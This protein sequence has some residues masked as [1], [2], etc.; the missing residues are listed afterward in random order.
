MCLEIR[1]AVW[2]VDGSAVLTG[3][4]SSYRN[5]APKRGPAWSRRP[6][7]EAVRSGTRT[8]QIGWAA[9]IFPKKI[10]MFF[11]NQ[12]ALQMPSQYIFQ[13]TPQIISKLTLSPDQMGSGF[14]AKK[15]LSLSKINPRSRD[16][17]N[18]FCEKLLRF[19]SNQ[20]TTHLWLYL[21]FSKK[22]L[23]ETLKLHLRCSS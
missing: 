9:V 12:P 21:F 11:E 17:L 3:R 2:F 19:F 5:S 23:A 18:N 4:A 1:P 13:K 22:K 16:P 14:F 20:H 7:F 8:V 15:T 10:L 6:L